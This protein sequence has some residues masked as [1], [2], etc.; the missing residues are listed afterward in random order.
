VCPQPRPV[1][2]SHCGGFLSKLR[3]HRH[4]VSDTAP[5]SSPC[6]SCGFQQ[7]THSAFFLDFPKEGTHGEGELVTMLK[8][9]LGTWPWVLSS[10]PSSA[11]YW[12]LRPWP[13][14]Y[15]FLASVSSFL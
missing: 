4:C 3:C 8:S 13:S 1:P 6:V 11:A 9:V 5:C 14:P 12:L 2:S 7:T 10:N 15:L